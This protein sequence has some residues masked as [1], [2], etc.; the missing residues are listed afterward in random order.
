MTT[1][2]T[3]AMHEN[4][5]HLAA[6]PPRLIEIRIREVKQ[7]FNSMDPS[8]FNERDLDRDADEY[9]VNWAHE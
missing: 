7:L 9:I 8:P 5:L 6:G 1:G 2:L 4:S 3:T